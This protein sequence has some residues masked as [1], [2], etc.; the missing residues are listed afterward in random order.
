VVGGAEIVADDAEIVAD[1]AKIV[2][3]DEV[4]ADSCFFAFFSHGECC[5]TR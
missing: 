3:D 1:N 5:G 2:A 4:D